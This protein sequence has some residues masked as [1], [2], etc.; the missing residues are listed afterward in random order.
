MV[1][2]VTKGSVLGCGTPSAYLT[3][4]GGRNRLAVLNLASISY[5]RR[6]SDI[7]DCRIELAAEQD[8][9]CMSRLSNLRA[10]RYEVSVFRDSDEV[11]V[12]PLVEPTYV[13]DGMSLGAR[14]LFN[15]FERRVHPVDRALTADLS[16]IF[17]QYMTDAMLN[18]SSPNIT[19]NIN[20]IGVTGTRA[21][22]ALQYPRVADSLRELSRSGVD[23]TTI[24][25]EVSVFPEVADDPIL[26]LTEDIF[27]VDS[28]RL[29]GLD[30][31]NQITILGAQPAGVT[32][33]LV[34]QAGG[35]DV[36]LVQ[37]VYTDPTILDIPSA[38][39][40]AEKRWVLLHEAPVSVTGRLLENASID[41]NSLIPGKRMRLRQQ[42]GF[43]T[44]DEVLRLTAVDV[45]VKVS[46]S[47]VTETVK[48]SLAP[49]GVT[50]D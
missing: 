47:D 23:F 26:N 28:V 12:G 33:P 24:G 35:V 3:E 8:D 39:S 41:F 10:W 25:R 17:A 46:D 2:T 29:A 14:D 45:D 22:Q 37:Q 7:S 49:P 27:E 20:P 13:Y 1:L 40:A 6:L 5:S 50:E 16:A 19:F 30:M 15:W 4:V 38:T 18:D 11:W 42:V 31:G 9:R 36:P 21:V 43:R 34:G 44:F 32:T 48:L